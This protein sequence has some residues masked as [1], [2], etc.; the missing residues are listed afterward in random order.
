[1]N[2]RTDGA[3]QPSPD[4]ARR[5]KEADRQAKRN[6]AALLGDAVLNGYQGSSEQLLKPLMKRLPASARAT[7]GAIREL[8]YLVKDG[9][10]LAKAKDMGRAA[11]GFIGA[12]GGA[13]ALGAAG[14]A[15]GSLYT[16]PAAPFVAPVAA[17][18]GAIIGA[19]AGEKGLQYV[20][21]HA[22]EVAAAVRQEVTRALSQD[23]GGPRADARARQVIMTPPR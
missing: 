11:A 12:R 9:V 17:G 4:H 7:V 15:A 8:P 10:S 2:E 1:M 3:P 21:D 13:M 6:T 14:G 18:G 19:V 20:Y 22:D 23:Q 5:R 16:G